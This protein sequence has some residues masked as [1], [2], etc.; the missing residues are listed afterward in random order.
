[1]EKEFKEL[2][3]E[4]FRQPSTIDEK[5]NL[6]RKKVP[7]NHFRLSNYKFHHVLP[8]THS[9]ISARWWNRGGSGDWQYVAWMSMKSVWGKIRKEKFEKKK[10]SKFSSDSNLLCSCDLHNEGWD[11]VRIWFSVSNFVMVVISC[12]RDYRY[13]RNVTQHWASKKHS[14]RSFSQTDLW[15]YSDIFPSRSP[16]CWQSISY[17]L[18]AE[19]VCLRRERV[20]ER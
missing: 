16:D 2:F 11:F 12:F 15:H 14:G 9:R 4:S 20:E 13:Y 1:M 5:D 7:E 8:R 10:I 19:N 18:T 3:S 6:S 17:R